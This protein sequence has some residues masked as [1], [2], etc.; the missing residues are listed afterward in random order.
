MHTAEAAAAPAVAPA[1]APAS[2]GTFLQFF[3]KCSGPS[4][5]GPSNLFR[6][7][8]FRVTE[9]WNHLILIKRDE[10]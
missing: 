8:Y 2:P 7:E 5:S 10:L 4:S 6:I 1:A 3:S 9:V